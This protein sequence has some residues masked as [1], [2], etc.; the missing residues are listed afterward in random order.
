MFSM[1][2]PEKIWYQKLI[3]L[4]ISP[5]SCNQFTFRNPKSH[6]QQY[7]RFSH[8]KSHSNRLIFDR[9]SQKIKRRT[10]YLGHSVYRLK[11]PLWF[12]YSLFMNPKFLLVGVYMQTCS[13][14]PRFA[15]MGGVYLPHSQWQPTG[16]HVQFS[17]S[18]FYAAA[19]SVSRI[20]PRSVHCLRG[21]TDSFRWFCSRCCNIVSDFLGHMLSTVN[22]V[23]AVS[24]WSYIKC[25]IWF[26]CCRNWRRCPQWMSEE[27][28]FTLA[29]VCS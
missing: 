26:V 8:T 19:W 13:Y 25:D 12:H 24:V 7:Y 27:T 5:D 11:P 1:W 21:C 4:P 20:R 23:S 29:T 28:S 6:L 18:A 16:N 17:C 22:S 10:D 3:N 9:V 2:S 15:C 14:C